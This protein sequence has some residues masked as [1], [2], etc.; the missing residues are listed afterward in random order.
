M[1]TS[2]LVSQQSSALNHLLRLKE[3]ASKVLSPSSSSCQTTGAPST[4]SLLFDPVAF[5][6][7]MNVLK[8]LLRLMKSTI[9]YDN[10]NKDVGFFQQASFRSHCRSSRYT[11]GEWNQLLETMKDAPVKFMWLKRPLEALCAPLRFWMMQD[12]QSHDRA[13]SLKPYIKKGVTTYLS[14]YVYSKVFHMFGVFAANVGMGQAVMDNA[15]VL[16]LQ[17]N[18][19][20]LSGDAW[21]TRRNLFRDIL[22]VVEPVLQWCHKSTRRLS[23]EN[24]EPLESNRDILVL[25]D[26]KN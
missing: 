2:S 12:A 1:A 23:G 15:D 11:M 10:L 5:V 22:S 14:T 6:E 7:M 4:N 3:H 8:E 9:L 18:T 16:L 26:L 17:E 20:Y 21:K 25:H 13:P 24:G 19:Q